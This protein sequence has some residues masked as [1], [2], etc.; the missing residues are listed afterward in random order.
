MVLQHREGLKQL[1]YFFS[2]FFKITTTRPNTKAAEFVASILSQKST[3]FMNS[4]LISLLTLP[5]TRA[6]FFWR[7]FEQLLRL[8]RNAT[9]VLIKNSLSNLTIPEDKVG[10]VTCTNERKEKFLF[11]M[12]RANDASSIKEALRLFASK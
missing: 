7:I 9:I 10:L 1:V 2:A 11:H 4:I 12:E 3:P 6:P 8:D 5:L